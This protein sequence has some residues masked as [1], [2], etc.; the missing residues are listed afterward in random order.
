MKNI[1]NQSKI[2][3]CLTIIVIS[4][5]IFQF[6][7]IAK[8]S[9]AAPNP[10]H[11]WTETECDT[12]FCVDTTNHLV[13][14]GTTSPTQKLDVDGSVK[15]SGN[16]TVGGTLSGR[17]CKKVSSDAGCPTGYYVVSADQTDHWP[18]SVPTGIIINCCPATYTNL[19]LHCN[20]ADGST[21]FINSSGLAQVI[22]ASG[23]AQV[24]TAQSYF[25]GA[26][27]LFDGSGDYLSTLDSDDWYFGTGDFTIDFWVRYN[28]LPAVGNYI[29]LFS[30]YQD[31]SNYQRIYVYNDSGQ[32]RVIYQA[33]SGGS[34]VISVNN[35]GA[36]IGSWHHIAVTRSG[37]SFKMFINGNDGGGTYFSSGAI[38]NLSANVT[39]GERNGGEYFDGWIDEFRISK[40]IAR[41]TSNFTPPTQ[42]YLP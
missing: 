17:I 10:G 30:Q 19:L 12:N 29:A 21:T 11:A 23:N 40:G 26:S 7:E 22:T 33:V 14:V 9:P 36:S 1:F 31:A 18:D 20:G 27:G 32:Y 3:I 37:T 25:G 39:I 28:S 34:E 41:W 2:I 42:E 8:A 35:T 38:P 16:L 15:A 6:I 13:G 24:D 4:G 5:L